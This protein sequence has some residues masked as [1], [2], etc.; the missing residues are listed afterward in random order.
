M[1]FTY[2]YKQKP[3]S[4][5]LFYVA[6]KASQYPNLSLKANKSST[7][8]KHNGWQRLH[9]AWKSDNIN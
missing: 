1:L 5:F 9:E 2:F 7:K 4:N 8:E 3:F 6:G